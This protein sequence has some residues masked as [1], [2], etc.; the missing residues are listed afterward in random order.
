MIPVNKTVK[1]IVTAS[2]VIHSWTVASF[3]L[4]IDAV[5]GRLNEDWFRLEQPG[6]FYG[7]CSEL[8]GKDHAFMPVAVRGVAEAD[9]DAW[10][11]KAKTAG[12]EEA[13]K[14][15]A[16]LA[17]PSARLAEAAAATNEKQ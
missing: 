10:V 4:K 12:V 7:Q 2:D 17:S 13:N 16:A 5:P 11:Q 15:L 3:G 14:M 9:F 8:C 6:V 1:I